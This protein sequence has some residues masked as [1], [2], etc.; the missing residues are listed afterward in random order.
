MLADKQDNGSLY[1]GDEYTLY[2]TTM[3]ACIPAHAAQM[4][5]RT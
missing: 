5:A 2:T 4:S 3:P 1:Q